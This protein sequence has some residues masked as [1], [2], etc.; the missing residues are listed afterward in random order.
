MRTVPGSPPLFHVANQFVL[1]EN[2]E[3][4]D[5][6]VKHRL[7]LLAEPV[8]QQPG[9]L[10]DGFL[11]VHLLPHKAAVLIQPDV[12][13]PGSFEQLLRQPVIKPLIHHMNGHDS[14]L[15]RIPGI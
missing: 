15:V 3:V 14:L 9:Y 6:S 7:R 11:S 2:P 10:V 1:V 5:Q 13:D 4:L 8:A 12:A